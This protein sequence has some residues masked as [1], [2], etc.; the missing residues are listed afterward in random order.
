MK[1]DTIVLDW[2]KEV[3]VYV[4]W[5]VLIYALPLTLYWTLIH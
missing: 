5:A 2:F 1:P 4:I 3:F